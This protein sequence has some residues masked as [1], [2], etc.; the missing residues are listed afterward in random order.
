MRLNE[1]ILWLGMLIAFLLLTIDWFAPNTGLWRFIGDIGM[2]IGFIT[3]ILGIIKVINQQ[4][5]K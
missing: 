1:N 3:V 5:G 4:S 2:A